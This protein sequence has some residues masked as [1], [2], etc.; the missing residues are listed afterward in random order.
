VLL[1]ILHNLLLCWCGQERLARIEQELKADDEQRH[2]EA[3]NKVRRIETA[4]QRKHAPVN[5]SEMVDE[6]FG[7]IDSQ[8]DGATEAGAPLAFKVES[9]CVDHCAAFSCLLEEMCKN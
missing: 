5:D 8:V 9:R 4:E 3:R 7:F 6:M 1:K 2:L